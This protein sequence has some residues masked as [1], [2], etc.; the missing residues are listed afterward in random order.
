MAPTWFR[1]VYA[2]TS[3]RLWSSRRGPRRA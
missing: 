3:P 1:D 2:D